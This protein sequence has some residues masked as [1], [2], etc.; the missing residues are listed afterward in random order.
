MT[1]FSDLI[2]ESGEALSNIDAV[3]GKPVPLDVLNR[4]LSELISSK[5]S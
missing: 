2:E 5:A 3:L 1:G 4:K